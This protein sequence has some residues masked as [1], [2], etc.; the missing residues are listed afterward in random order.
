MTGR[1]VLL[2]GIY[3]AINAPQGKAGS[4]S[5]VWGPQKRSVEASDLA[6]NAQRFGV[7]LNWHPNHPVR[8]VAGTVLRRCAAGSQPSVP[9]QWRR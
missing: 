9:S 2:G 7:T 3:Q 1:P 4:A 5:D 6:R 8:T